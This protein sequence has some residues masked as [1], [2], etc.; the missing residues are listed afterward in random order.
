MKPLSQEWVE[1][2][3]GDFTT[4]VRELRARKSPNFDAACFHAQQC[5]EKYLKARLQEAGIPFPRLHS[6]PALLDLVVAIEPLWE[7]QRGALATLSAFAV[8]VRYPGENADR[9]LAREAVV[10][11]GE[12]R[13]SAR[14]ALGLTPD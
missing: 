11:A 10:L 4:A 2:A 6:L 1:K 13:R 7:V 5:A 8:E 9:A 3:E 12:F 14:L